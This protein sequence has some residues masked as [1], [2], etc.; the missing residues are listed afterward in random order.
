[1]PPGQVQREASCFNE[2]LGTRALPTR[3]SG[4]GKDRPKGYHPATRQRFPVVKKQKRHQN[5]Q[6]KTPDI[7]FWLTASVIKVQALFALFFYSKL[8]P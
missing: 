5:R 3:T 4:K 1:M 6:S 2:Q 8:K 7:D